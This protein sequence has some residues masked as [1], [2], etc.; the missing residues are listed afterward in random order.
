M[1]VFF[2]GKHKVIGELAEMFVFHK[3]DSDRS[4]LLIT[5]VPGI[6]IDLDLD[7]DL[8]CIEVIFHSEIC[9]TMSCIVG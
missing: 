6:S 1:V 7:R 9:D 5:T 4:P 8:Y 2:N 3:T